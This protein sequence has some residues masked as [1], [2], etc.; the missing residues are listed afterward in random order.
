M[1]GTMYYLIAPIM[2]LMAL[3]RAAQATTHTSDTPKVLMT[4]LGLPIQVAAGYR[5]I[6]EIRL[7]GA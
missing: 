5:G 6:A 1:H 4:A 2:G 7:G 3:A